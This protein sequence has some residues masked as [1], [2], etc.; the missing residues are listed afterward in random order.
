MNSLESESLWKYSFI[1]EKAGGIRNAIL[2][3]ECDI[4]LAQSYKHTGEEKRVMGSGFSPL[5]IRY[6]SIHK[7]MCSHRFICNAI[8]KSVIFRTAHGTRTPET[9]IFFKRIY[10]VFKNKYAF[11]CSPNHLMIQAHPQMYPCMSFSFNIFRWFPS[12]PRT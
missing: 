9:C 10:I 11:Y 3:R 2:H 8:L 4:Q 7:Q 12:L 6:L 5:Y 1:L